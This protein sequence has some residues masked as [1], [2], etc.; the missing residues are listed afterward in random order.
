MEKN[1]WIQKKEL[2]EKIKKE[3]ND[4]DPEKFVCVNTDGTILTLKNL[5][6]QQIWLPILTETRNYLKM[7]K[8]NSRT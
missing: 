8:I 7:Q 5:K 2:F 3:K 4:I 6:I 1:I